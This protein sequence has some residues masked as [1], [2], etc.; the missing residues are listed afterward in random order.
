MPEEFVKWIRFRLGQNSKSAKRL[1]NKLM[2][3]QRNI[4]EWLIPDA[5][6]F[7]SK[8]Q[9]ACNTHS[10]GSYAA[11]LEPSRLY[12]LTMGST[13]IGYAILWQ[14]LGMSS[15]QIRHELERS[16]FKSRVVGWLHQQYLKKDSD[17]ALMSNEMDAGNGSSCAKADKMLPPASINARTFSCPAIASSRRLA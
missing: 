3:R 10:Y 8:Q 15:A 17:G 13:L 9:E 7:V 14:L 5:E 2:E 16:Y 6:A 12:W 4:A 11:A 1:M